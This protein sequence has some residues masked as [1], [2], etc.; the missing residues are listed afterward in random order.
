[1]VERGALDMLLRSVPVREREILRLRYYEDLT[2]GEIGRRIGVSQMQVSRI[3]RQALG[4]LQAASTGE[5]A[6][7]GALQRS[8]ASGT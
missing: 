6:L 5:P 4:R 8:T 2:Q 7:A 3:L 1:V